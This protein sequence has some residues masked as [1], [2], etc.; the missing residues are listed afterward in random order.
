MKRIVAGEEREDEGARAHGQIGEAP[1]GPRGWQE[2]LWESIARHVQGSLHEGKRFFRTGRWTLMFASGMTALSTVGVRAAPGVRAVPLRGS[3]WRS[4]LRAKLAQYRNCWSDRGFRVALLQGVLT[5]L[6]SLIVNY[7]AGTYASLRAGAPVRD[8]ILDR[9]PTLPVN[10]IFIDG[11]FLFWMFVLAVLLDIPRT[12]PFVLK[13]LSAFIVIRS[14]FVILTHV[15]PPAHEAILQPNPIMSDLTFSGD[16]F[17]SGH[18]GFPFLLALTFWE[19]RRL[20]NFF[21]FS[22]VIF[23]AAVL[24]GHLHYSID[25]FAAFFITDSIFRLAQRLFRD[26]YRMLSDGLQARRPWSSLTSAAPGC[27]PAEARR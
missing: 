11:A 13:V 19:S 26:E 16:L 23:A 27:R 22:A 6:S 1:P 20:R 21:L 8:F 10:L 2:R 5:L 25:V 17:F 24:T 18:T 14:F 4:A 12:V 7:T 3:A 9:V 15:G